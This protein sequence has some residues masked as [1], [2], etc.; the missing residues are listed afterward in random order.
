MKNKFAA[1]AFTHWIHHWYRNTLR[2]PKWRWAL[3][4]GSFVYLL[5]PFDFLPDMVPLVGWI[6]DGMIATLLVSEVSQLLNDRRKG[7]KDKAASEV[8]VETTASV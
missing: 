4:L 1:K 3:I 8:T 7:Q 6:D 5:N 2:H